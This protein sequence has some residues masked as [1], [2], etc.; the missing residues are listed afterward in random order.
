VSLSAALGFGPFGKLERYQLYN[1]VA[2]IWTVEVI[3]SGNH[4]HPSP[5][6]ALPPDA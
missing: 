4:A 3:G 6:L 1:V 2:A 5:P